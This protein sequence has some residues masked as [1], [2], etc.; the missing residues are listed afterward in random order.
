MTNEVAAKADQI[1]TLLDSPARANALESEQFKKFLDQ[2]PIAICV[3]ELRDEE[4]IIYANP[5]F[6]R[7]SGL[8]AAKLFRQPWSAL[9]G[10]G[11]GKEKERSIANAIVQD[12]IA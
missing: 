9:S 8:S 10:E 7:L 6:E 11:V 3:A 12:A 2:V 1:E 4:L 5:E